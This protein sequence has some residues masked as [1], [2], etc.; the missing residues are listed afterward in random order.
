MSRDKSKS[1]SLSF[2]DKVKTKFL[3]AYS[4]RD[5]SHP[6]FDAS[7]GE[8]KRLLTTRKGL[9]ELEAADQSL[10][11][12]ITK[13]VRENQLTKVEFGRQLERWT[14]SLRAR[15]SGDTKTTLRR[16][17]KVYHTLTKSGRVSRPL[18]VVHIDLAD[19]NRLNPDK[20]KYRYPFILVAVD[21]FSNYCVLVPVKNKEA[22][23]V[24]NAIKN[25]FSQMGID[26]RAKRE[27]EAYNADRKSGA[28]RRFVDNPDQRKRWCLISTRLQG[29]KGKEFR[30]KT[31]L[32]YLSNKRIGLFSSRGSG[33]AYLAE[34][35]IGQMKSQLVR[36]QNILERNIKKGQL[37]RSKGASKKTRKTF[38]ETLLPSRR[39]GEENEENSTSEEQ[40]DEEDR[41]EDWK[42]YKT[43][44]SQYLRP[45]Q[46]KLN[47]KRNLRTGYKPTQL[48]KQ[49]D[50][51]KNPPTAKKYDWDRRNRVNETEKLF[52]PLHD[53]I[54][55]INLLN[56]SGKQVERAQKKQLLKAQEKSESQNKSHS[57]KK[58]PKRGDRVFLTHSRLMGHPNDKPLNIFDKRS[59]QT[60]SEWDTSRPYIVTKIIGDNPPRYRVTNEATGQM[61]KTAYYREELLLERITAL[62]KKKSRK[63]KS[64]FD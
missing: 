36:I 43:G 48:F 33:K 32:S 41:F 56:R 34:S 15:T 53:T 64:Q 52:E 47:N 7:K 39:T 9:T 45:L 17:T 27:Q 16:P 13:Y 29:D 49:F 1:K 51:S 63:K 40:Q 4:S 31:L 12:M 6:L 8:V 57:W 25:V 60:K 50:E 61:R 37:R 54:T 58:S 26:K 21:A 10:H 20:R 30:N 35:K 23:S 44:W 38:D 11:R 59:T 19:V 28:Q 5:I 3:R 14:D 18:D 55:K 2:K 24:T 42:E 22:G 46:K 62:K